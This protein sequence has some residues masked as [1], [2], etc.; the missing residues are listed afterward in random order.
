MQLIARGIPPQSPWVIDIGACRLSCSV[1]SRAITQQEIS[2]A[3]VKLEL[4][5]LEDGDTAAAHGCKFELA[6]KSRRFAIRQ[7]LHGACLG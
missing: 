7:A 5:L 2:E 4:I 3:L 6:F 1:C